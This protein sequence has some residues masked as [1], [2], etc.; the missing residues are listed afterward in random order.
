MFENLSGCIS[1]LYSTETS[2][3]PDNSLLCK[4]GRYMKL[5]DTP[6]TSIST[7]LDNI[8]HFNHHS[9]LTPDARHSPTNS[10][11]PPPPLTILWFPNLAPA[12][13]FP[14]RIDRRNSTTRSNYLSKA[15]LSPTVPCSGL[16][17]R[18]G[19][20]RD[21]LGAVVCRVLACRGSVE[22]HSRHTQVV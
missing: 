20:A 15:L 8:T 10:L 4:Q 19:R 2:A 12:Q 18:S 21:F 22:G 11:I 1:N 5:V 16:R 6:S 7:N 17:I 9:Q 13:L 14:A 3:H